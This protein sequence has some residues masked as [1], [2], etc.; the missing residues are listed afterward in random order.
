MPIAQAWCSICHVVSPTGRPSCRR[1][2]LQM[3]A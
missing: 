3:S 2:Q 1:A